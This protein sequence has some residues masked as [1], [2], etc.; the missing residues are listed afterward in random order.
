MKLRYTIPLALLLI[1]PL[2]PFSAHAAT[3]SAVLSQPGTDPSIYAAGNELAPAQSALLF[4]GAMGLVLV[5][6]LLVEHRS[7]RH[8][9]EALSSLVAVPIRE[10]TVL[11]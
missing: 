4:V 9:S 6:F 3:P 8:M 2:L 11:P 1:L 7:L 5:G 10:R